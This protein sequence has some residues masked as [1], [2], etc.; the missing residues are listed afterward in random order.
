MPIRRQAQTI[1]MHNTTMKETFHDYPAAAR[2]IEKASRDELAALQL[3]RLKWSLNM[4]IENSPVYRRK[5]DEAGVHPEDVQVAR[6]SRAVPVHDEEGSAR[7]LSVRHV[8]R[9]ARTD[10][11]HSRFVRDDGQADRRRLHGEGH[12]HVGESRR[13]VDSRSGRA[14]RRQSAR[15]LRLRP[16]HRRTRRALRRGAGRPHRHSVRRRADGK[17][18]AAHPGF[19]ARHHHGHAELHAV[20]RR[21]NRAP[22]HRPGEHVAAHR[23]L[24]RGAVDQR[25]AL[26]DRKAHGH[27]C[28]RYLRSVG[29][30]R[31][32]RGVGV[33]GNQGRP[34]DLGRPLL[35][36]NHRSD[37]GRT[38]RGRRIRRTRVYFVDER[39]AARSSGI[40]R[41]ISRGSCPAPRARC[42]AWKRSP[43]ARTT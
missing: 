14:A 33:R 30:D 35:S 28:R 39:G 5:F 37:H 10:F 16:F 7:Q 41:A 38:C 21:R 42:A 9:A 19:P 43:D 20:D 6:R 22:G 12:R 4:R 8:R 34:D 23:H 2:A 17:A 25:H 26:G 15:Q 31:P 29:S 40:A 32:G 3:E 24:R 27:R 36:R 11:A 1:L 13:A 18:G